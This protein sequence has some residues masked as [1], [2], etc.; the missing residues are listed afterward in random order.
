MVENR[1]YSGRTAEF[2]DGD[3][4]RIIVPLDEEYSFDFQQIKSKEQ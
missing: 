4:F 2:I 3:I 1:Y